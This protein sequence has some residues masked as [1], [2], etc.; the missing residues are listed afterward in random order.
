MGLGLELVVGISRLSDIHLYV[1]FGVRVRVSDGVRLSD[2]VR[3]RVEV[4]VRRI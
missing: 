2:G 4:R 3:V 1:R